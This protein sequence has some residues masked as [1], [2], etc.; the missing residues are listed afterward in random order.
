M[1]WEINAEQV[2]RIA[3]LL[4]YD[5]PVEEIRRILLNERLTEEQAMLTYYAAK[6]Y[7]DGRIK[8]LKTAAGK[9]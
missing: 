4:S 7:R 6:V 8:E 5:T 2:R 1:R 3:H 9:R